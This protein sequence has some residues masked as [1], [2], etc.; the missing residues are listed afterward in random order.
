M[1]HIHSIILICFISLSAFGQQRSTGQGTITGQ[2]LEEASNTP[3]EFATVSLLSP[4][5]SKVVTGGISDEKGM[6]EVKAS[7][8]TYLVKIEFIGYESMQ[9]DDIVLNGTA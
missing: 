2:L 3:L 1:K 8:G 5:D 6:F 4:T 7:F 9:L